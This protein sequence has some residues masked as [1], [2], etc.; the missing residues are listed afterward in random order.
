MDV[1]GKVAALLAATCI[2]TI[3]TPAMAQSKYYMRERIVGMPISDGPRQPDAPRTFSPVYSD[4]FGA[5]T[6]GT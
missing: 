4:A 1:N 6:G 2:M 5:C 3:T